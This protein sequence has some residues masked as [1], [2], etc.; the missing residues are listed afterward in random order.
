LAIVLCHPATGEPSGAAREAVWLLVETAQGTL[1]VMRGDRAIRQFENISIGR[2]GVALHRANGED[3]T[4]QGTF[5]IA[6]IERDSRFHRFFGLDYPRQADALWGLRTGKIDVE[7]Y[8][9]IYRATRRG[10]VPPQD[11]ALGGYIGIH[12]LGKGDP[13]MHESL[14]W[15]NG[16]VALTNQQVDQLE[17]WISEGTTVIIR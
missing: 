16:C 7:T 4:P 15:T 1:S 3:A 6:W 17:P 13:Q 9:R 14:N 2:G 8:A 12:G 5:R 11:T 10:Q